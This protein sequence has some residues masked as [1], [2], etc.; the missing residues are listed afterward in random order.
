MLKFRK[1]SFSYGRA[2]DPVFSGLDLDLVQG[3]RMVIKG[4]S[5]SGKTSLLRLILGFEQPSS[6]TIF[7]RGM[8]LDP[9]TLHLL[10]QETAWL[11]QDLDL[12]QGL[13]REVLLFPF[14]FRANAAKRPSYGEIL[15]VLAQLNLEQKVWEQD[16][17]ELSTGQRQ[18]LG[19]ALCYLLGK[20]VLLLDEPTSA[21][22]EQS[23]ER[24]G[25][26]LF[27]KEITL[28]STSH[29]PWWI[30]RCNKIIRI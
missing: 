4:E 30:K 5:G 27:Q 8:P 17:R 14:R 15:G 13:V 10:R 29:D 6:G 26:L 20:R 25:E 21:L 24:V 2:T 9:R 12:G 16:F 3:D 18:R 1:I 7:Y 11:P 22:D 23:R 28:I 19:I